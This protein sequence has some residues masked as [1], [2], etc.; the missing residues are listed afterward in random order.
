MSNFILIISFFRF[1]WRWNRWNWFWSVSSDDRFSNAPRTQQRFSWSVQMRNF[2][3]T[4]HSNKAL[5]ENKKKFNKKIRDK[6]F[7]YKL[8][9]CQ[10]QKRFRNQL[11]RRKATAKSNFYKMFFFI[12]TFLYTI[13]FFFN[14]FNINHNLI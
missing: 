12:L 13:S 3:I 1:Y 4:P 9:K 11:E 10:F 8:K 6:N 14:F 2:V 5:S 7:L